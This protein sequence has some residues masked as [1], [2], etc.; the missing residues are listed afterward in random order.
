MGASILAH[1]KQATPAGGYTVMQVYSG[2][3]V[4]DGA[5]G[6]GS[7]GVR[8]VGVRWSVSQPNV[9]SVPF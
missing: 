2:V 8:Y 1:T 4:F 3:S 7:V 5:V 9:T 6:V